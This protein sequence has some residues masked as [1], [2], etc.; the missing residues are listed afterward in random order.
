MITSE[1]LSPRQ[2]VSDHTPVERLRFVVADAS[3]ECLSVVCALL[4]LEDVIDIVGRA[5]SFDEAFKLVVG[6]SADVVLV[7]L[8]MP[9]AHVAISAIGLFARPG[10]RIIGMTSFHSIALLA[11]IP[12]LAVNALVHKERLPQELPLLLNQFYGDA[13][14]ALAPS[15]FDQTVDRSNADFPSVDR[16][17]ADPQFNETAN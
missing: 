4:A 10:T 8:E 11:P 5:T 12:M 3:S 13:A 2:Q 7:D 15:I 16:P 9:L 14:S 1:R 17:W 6:C